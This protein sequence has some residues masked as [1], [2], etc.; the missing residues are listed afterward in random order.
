MDLQL[1]YSV[2]TQ[3]PQLVVSKKFLDKEIFVGTT[4]RELVFDC[5]NFYLVKISRYTAFR[6]Q[7]QADM[8]FM[9]VQLI[10]IGCSGIIT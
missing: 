8:Q 4:F 1:E 10:T 7:N 5:K 6:G 3:L 9:V 2:L